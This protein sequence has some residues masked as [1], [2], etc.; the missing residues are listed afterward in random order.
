MSRCEVGEKF[1]KRVYYMNVISRL[2]ALSWGKSQLGR[3]V[4]GPCGLAN[5]ICS[6]R[7]EDTTP[8]LQANANYFTGKY[9]LACYYEYQVNVHGLL[10]CR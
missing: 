9:F 5:F 2:H 3:N 7:I 10:L 6:S 4:E 1:H 8:V